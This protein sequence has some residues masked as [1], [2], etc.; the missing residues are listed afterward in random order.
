[1]YPNSSYNLVY[2][3]TRH[4]SN[5]STAAVRVLVFYFNNDKRVYRQQTYLDYFHILVKQYLELI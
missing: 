3:K 5:R 4:A 1:M 2:K